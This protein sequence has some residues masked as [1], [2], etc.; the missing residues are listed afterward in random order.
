M[1][2]IVHAG[3]LPHP[4]VMVPEV[5]KEETYRVSESLA[6]ARKF[7]RELKAFE[8]EVIV[9]I[10][11]HGAVF[12]DAVAINM[13]PELKGDLKQFGAAQVKFRLKNDLQLAEAITRLSLGK[14][15]A[16]AQVDE[17]LG[18]EYQVGTALDHGAMVPLYFLQEA[19]VN[20]PLVHITMGLLPLEELYLFGTLIQDAVLMSSRKAAVIASGDLSHRLTPDAPAGY[21]P[22]GKEFDAEMRR[23]LEA[24]DAP[25]II[26]L[27]SD[28]VE[29]AGECGFRP[30][31]ML[32]GALDGYQ[33]KGEVLSYE[34]PFGVGYLV[35]ALKPQGQYRELRLV[36]RLF[37]ARTEKIKNARKGES[38]A[39]R[40]ARETLEAYVTT[41]KIIATPKEVPREWPEQAGTF[42]SLKKHG[43]LRG[44]IGTTAPTRDSTAEEIIYNAI[45][46][47]TQD[48]RFDPV[49]TDEL[50]QLTYSVDILGEPEKIP[51]PSFLDP[52][53]YGVIVRQGRRSGLL[54]PDLEGIDTVEEQVAIAKRKAGI[55]G[56]EYT[57]ERF[58]VTRYT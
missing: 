42:V 39:V 57:L 29:Q 6:A 14:G 12:R 22:R 35:A 13:V 51:D 33:V 2:E 38:F 26:N 37:N 40:L 23:L 47:G 46:A 11:P 28:L 53:K 3:F 9:L 55:T 43:Q 7:A 45:A 27:P 15:I 49:T 19:G 48:P 16:V 58:K 56:N 18:R 25:G 36:N 10:T 41:G 17:E 32:L 5:G 54:L 21:H 30:L 8:P 52:K 31:V 4:P 24:V 34:G 44:C 20:V 1:G 50:D